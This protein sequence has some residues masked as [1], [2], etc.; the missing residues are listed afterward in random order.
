MDVQDGNSGCK[1]RIKVVKAAIISSN[2]NNF[3]D[4][5]LG[6]PGPVDKQVNTGDRYGYHMGL[7]GVRVTNLLTKLP[8][9]SKW[10]LLIEMGAVAEQIRDLLAQEAEPAARDLSEVSQNLLVLSK[11]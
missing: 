7:W 9:P 2:T 11:E 4:Y 10:R 5:L 3:L 6:G 8:C 1:P